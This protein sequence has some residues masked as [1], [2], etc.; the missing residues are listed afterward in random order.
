MQ[1]ELHPLRGC[2]PTWLCS[3]EGVAPLGKG[4][5]SQA[6]ECAAACVLGE[7]GGHRVGVVTCPLG[8]LLRGG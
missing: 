1:P 4:T 6:A 8:R 7:R 3:G 2:A 5:R